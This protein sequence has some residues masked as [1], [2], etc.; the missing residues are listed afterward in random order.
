MPAG[1]FSTHAS[2]RKHRIFRRCG[3]TIQNHSHGDT[4]TFH[5]TVMT[6]LGY[7]GPELPFFKRSKVTWVTHGY[8]SS[9][10]HHLYKTPPGFTRNHSDIQRI[11]VVFHHRFTKSCDWD[12]ETGMDDFSLNG[13]LYNE[14][15][16]Y[17]L[18]ETNIAPA[19][20]PSRKETSLP[21]IPFSVAMLVSGR[22]Y[23]QNTQNLHP[24]NVVMSIPSQTILQISR[25]FPEEN[26]TK[27]GN[28]Y[29][30]A[31]GGPSSTTSGKYLQHP[32]SSQNT[33]FSRSKSIWYTHFMAWCF[34][35]WKL[36]IPE[37]HQN[38]D[39]KITSSMEFTQ[40]K[41]S[42][43]NQPWGIFASP[44]STSTPADNPGEAVLVPRRWVTLQPQRGRGSVRK[45]QPTALCWR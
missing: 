38:F 35:M 3:A 15:L 29:L 6:W 10:V 16:I 28:A 4:K 33:T 37:F 30:A 22:V 5:L 2:V 20:K 39:I 17:T 44:E 18:P 27:R 8:P 34:P 25:D 24:T 43:K 42:K 36:W 9:K 1:V 7:P 26:D 14:L 13:E 23:T 21:T 19:R 45:N 31:S 11:M 41:K 12:I 40:K 32:K